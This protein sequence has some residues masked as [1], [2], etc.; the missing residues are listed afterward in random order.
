MCTSIHY[1]IK[2]KTTQRL[3][4]SSQTGIYSRPRP[5]P[6]APTSHPIISPVGSTAAPVNTGGVEL[7]NGAEPLGNIPE[8]VVERLGKIG[9]VNDTEDGILVEMTGGREGT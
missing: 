9:G 1:C 4:I 5:T 8:E 6:A 2:H 3:R 7:D